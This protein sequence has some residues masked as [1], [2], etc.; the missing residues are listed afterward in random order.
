[1]GHRT[2]GLVKSR[3]RNL[4]D[5]FSFYNLTSPQVRFLSVGPQTHSQKTHSQTASKLDRGFDRLPGRPWGVSW[6][7]RLL[8]DGGWRSAVRD[9]QHPQE[10]TR[11]EPLRTPPG[12]SRQSD[13]LVKVGIGA[14]RGG[15]R[16][17]PFWTPHGRG[18]ESLGV[19]WGNGTKPLFEVALGGLNP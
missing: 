5:F 14:S 18:Y 8:P 7:A 19:S 6:A 9:Q 1:M 4:T 3:K 13:F 16:R 11:Q 15:G 2:R 10:G 12:A 17:G